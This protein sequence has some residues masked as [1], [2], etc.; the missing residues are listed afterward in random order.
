MFKMES[1]LT[2]SIAE[3]PTSMLKKYDPCEMIKGLPCQPPIPDYE[4]SKLTRHD[5][6]VAKNSEEG[7]ITVGLY[8]VLTVDPASQSVVAKVWRP[9]QLLEFFQ[10]EALVTIPWQNIL[11]S[12]FKLSSRMIPEPVQKAVFSLLGGRL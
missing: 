8:Q 11:L 12:K 5:F 3:Y 9:N 2:V 4:P 7:P 10:T 1:G 6:V